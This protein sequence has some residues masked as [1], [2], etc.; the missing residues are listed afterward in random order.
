MYDCVYIVDK[1]RRITYWNG[2]SESLTGFSRY[3]VMGKRCSEDILNHIDVNGLLLC[4]GACQIIK[5]MRDGKGD[6]FRVYPRK[7]NGIRF[8]VETVISPVFDHDGKIIA[9]TEVY[10]DISLQEEHRILWEKFNTLISNTSPPP[11]TATF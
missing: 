7:K 1:D 11:P 9:C 4:R 2:S 10:R 5:V 8:L 6:S 3:E